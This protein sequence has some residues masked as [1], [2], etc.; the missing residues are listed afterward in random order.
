M[1]MVEYYLL[2]Y[3][4]LIKAEPKKFSSE[5]LARWIQ[6]KDNEGFCCLHYAVFAQNYN[7]TVLL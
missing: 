2:E 6:A 5:N 7:M 1:E 3:E 4:K